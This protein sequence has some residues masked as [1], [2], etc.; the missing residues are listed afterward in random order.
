MLGFDAWTCEMFIERIWILILFMTAA[1]ILS[2]SSHRNYLLLFNSTLL[3]DSKQNF[4]HV[5][6]QHH[7]THHELVQDVVNLNGW[8]EDR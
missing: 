8:S 6:F 2:W 4:C 7:A 1:K 3:F 5:S